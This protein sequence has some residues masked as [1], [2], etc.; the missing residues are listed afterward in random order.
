MKRL[1]LLFILTSIVAAGCTDINLEQP[2]ETLQYMTFSASVLE[3]S[4]S[5]AAIDGLD[6]KWSEGDAIGIFDGTAVRKFTL[7][8]GAGKTTATFEGDAESADRYVAVYPYSNRL[9]VNNDGSISGLSI[10]RVQS[11]VNNGVDPKLIIMA[12][13]TEDDT[14]TF[15]FKNVVSYV[16]MTPQFACNKIVFETDM[17]SG[18]CGDIVVSPSAKSVTSQITDG[19]GSSSVLIDGPLEAGGTYYIATVPCTATNG[20]AAIFD[21]AD[22]NLLYIRNTD[23]SV[24]LARSHVLNL[25]SFDISTTSWTQ[26]AVKLCGHDVP[27][28]TSSY[29]NGYRIY[30]WR[31]LYRYASCVQNGGRGGNGYTM[32]YLMNDIDF[33]GRTLEPIVFSDAT[34][35]VIY[36][37]GHKIF[38]Y[39]QGYKDVDNVR[40]AGLTYINNVSM[41]SFYDLTLSPRTFNVQYDKVIYGGGFVS[42]GTKGH[43][44]MVISFHGCRFKGDLQVKCTGD[45]LACAGGFAGVV[46]SDLYASDCVVEEGSVTA[47][48]VDDLAYAGGIVGFCDP[49][50][51]GGIEDIVDR[52]AAHVQITRC[53]NKAYILA[54]GDDDSG[55]SPLTTRFDGICAGGL[56]GRVTDNVHTDAKT[57]INSCV[58]EAEVK[59]WATDNDYA[60]AGGMIGCHDSDGY[61]NA[62]GENNPSVENS[63]NK[64]V[65]TAW[66]EDSG[67]RAG[68]MV[69]ACHDNDTKFLNCVNI[70]ALVAN[71]GKKAHISGTYGSY[72]EYKCWWN[73]NSYYGIFKSGDTDGYAG[74]IPASMLN[75][76]KESYS[77]WSGQNGSLDLDF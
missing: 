25:G 12:A 7:K 22:D 66:S 73:D 67:S 14:K 55:T 75:G 15:A 26:R 37:E 4:V 60:Y 71:G 5:K 59:A 62:Y 57:V 61:I 20:F 31:D 76:G 8:E 46:Y 52:Y 34:C 49:D 36:G 69:G 44:S 41:F 48:S 16:K 33:G 65:V 13:A 50:E 58:N 74:N 70:G 63:L 29:Y 18:I 68:G 47:W 54:E 6:I 51:Y 40:Y 1:K 38:N 42:R 2:V 10:P 30:D 21:S 27:W 45:A 3:A 11:A 32:A 28:E 35:I 17:T 53:R 24:E 39:D 19:T 9:A 77:S 72:G 43:E 23:K 64:G 56:I